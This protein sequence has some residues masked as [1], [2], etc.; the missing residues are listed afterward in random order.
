MQTLRCNRLLVLTLQ[1]NYW[2]HARICHVTCTCAPQHERV[3]S[4]S[5]S[6]KTCR[7][8]QA[9]LALDVDSAVAHH[10]YNVIAQQPTAIR[11]DGWPKLG[12]FFFFFFF[13]IMS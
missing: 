6:C 13:S 7:A 12:I 10:S 4:A 9:F 8:T 5:T 11:L 2:H 1:P 3:M